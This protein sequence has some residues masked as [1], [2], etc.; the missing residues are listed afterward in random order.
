MEVKEIPLQGKKYT[1]SNEQSSPTMTHIDR[2]FCTPN[3]EE[4]YRQ[5]VIYPLSSSVSGHSPLFM[6]P[7]FQMPPNTKFRFESFWLE[8]PGFIDCVKQT[9]DKQVPTQHNP[10]MKLHIK[11]SRTAKALK[12]WS[13]SL[14]P[15]GRLTMALARRSFSDWT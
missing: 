8:L 7:I 4:L 9:W 12:T 5:P 14:I 1:W 13:R 10:F 3:W 6:A 11:L 2:I 15:S